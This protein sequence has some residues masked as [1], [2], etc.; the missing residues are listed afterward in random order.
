MNLTWLLIL[1]IVYLLWENRSQKKKAKAKPD[2]NE[3]VAVVVGAE[4]DFEI[5]CEKLYDGR[6][7]RI[8]LDSAMAVYTSKEKSI[9]AFPVTEEIL[10]SGDIFN[11]DFTKWYTT[12]T[13]N[14]DPF[15]INLLSSRIGNPSDSKNTED[16]EEEGS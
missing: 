16:A 10:S 2:L 1:S 6:F 8:Y 14:L 9:L 11:Y 13:V 4:R 15:Q 3:I 7:D 5:F 12:G